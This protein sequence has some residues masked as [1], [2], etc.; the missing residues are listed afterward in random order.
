MAEQTSTTESGRAQARGQAAQPEG[1]NGPDRAREEARFASEKAAAAA[2]AAVQ[3][4]AEMVE[5]HVETAQQAIQIG[6]DAAAQTF[7]ALA[8]AVADTFGLEGARGGNGAREVAQNVNAASKAGASLAMTAQEASRE[9]VG[10]TRRGVRRNLVAMHELMTCRSFRD[11]A[12]VQSRLVREHLE[13]AVKAGQSIAD[14]SRR[15]F[16]EVAR[17]FERERARP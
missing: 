16:G 2:Q 4:N 6:A 14:V 1:K 15:N 17:A 3:A 8:H 7:E 13:D 11:M 10:V 12:W 9:W 5:R